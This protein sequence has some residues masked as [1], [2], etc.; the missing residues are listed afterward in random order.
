MTANT[1]R[2]TSVR[3]VRKVPLTSLHTP[4]SLQQESRLPDEKKAYESACSKIPRRTEQSTILSTYVPPYLWP[5]QKEHPHLIPSHAILSSPISLSTTTHA[6]TPKPQNP[7]RSTC[8]TYCL[9]KGNSLLQATVISGKMTQKAAGLPQTINPARASRSS[10][11][12]GIYM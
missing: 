7:M 1:V 3:K 6:H 4:N 11:Y 12:I 5:S 2:S 9:H 8:E 10:S